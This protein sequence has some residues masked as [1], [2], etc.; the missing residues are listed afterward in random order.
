[1]KQLRRIERGAGKRWSDGKRQHYTGSYT[2]VAVD[3]YSRLACRRVLADEKATTA[4]AFLQRARAFFKRYGVRVERVL[5][6]N[7]SAY[8]AMIHALASRAFGV[9]HLRCDLTGPAD[10]KAERFIRTLAHHVGRRSH[11]PLEL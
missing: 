8:R 2:D 6:D 10:G 9:R 1:M 4:V 5:T 3:D 7:G 11:L